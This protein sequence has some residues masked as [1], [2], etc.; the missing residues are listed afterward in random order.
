MA[1]PVRKERIEGFLSME[2]KA[3]WDRY[4]AAHGVSM[5]ALLEALARHLDKPTIRMTKVVDE[6]RQIDAERRSRKPT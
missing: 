1:G 2:S 3:A 5:T 6:A 4:A